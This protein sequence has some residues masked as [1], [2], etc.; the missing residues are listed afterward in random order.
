M[1]RF[2]N[3]AYLYLLL[4]LPVLAGGFVLF[5]LKRKRDLA[6]FVG[7]ELQG[8]LLPN[9]SN[10]KVVLK[11]V[12]VLLAMAFLIVALAR[13]QFGTKLEKV[14][15][16]GIDIMVC[17][18]VSNSMLA[19]DIRPN[20]LSRSKQ[21]LQKLIDRLTGDRIGLVAFAGKAF[22]QLP[23]TSDYSAA[24]MFIDEL[25]VR[26]VAYQGTAVGEAIETAI[27]AF[28]ETVEG[29][30]PR[31]RAIILISD[32]ENF[33]D[34][35]F[36]AAELAKDAGIY[37]YSIGIGSVE[38]APIPTRVNG[39][40]D[41]KRDSNGNIVLTKLDNLTLQQIARKTGGVY[42]NATNSNL[43]LDKIFDKISKMEQT[44]SEETMVS[45]YEDRYEIPLLIAL[46]LLLCEFLIGTK[47]VPVVQ[48][49]KRRFLMVRKG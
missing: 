42:I 20:R 8:R 3:T 21:A 34:D 27:A 10:G 13:P 18:D 12:L 31:S 2:E 40:A 22:V 44:S 43:G 1:F 28:P 26:S 15:R 38:G 17:L 47:K 14:E 23:I 19:E 33:E 46:V 29:E 30:K 35:P 45:G 36:R 9:M 25:S 41:Y 4:V 24:K 6:A 49:L 7:G 5:L 11:F 39:K 37:I 48:E 16:K 32:G